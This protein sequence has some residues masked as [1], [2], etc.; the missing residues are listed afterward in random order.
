M[1]ILIFGMHDSI[2]IFTAKSIKN[3]HGDYGL[4]L[5]ILYTV[6]IIILFTVITRLGVIP[7]FDSSLFKSIFWYSLGI[8]THNHTF[9]LFRGRFKIVSGNIIQIL[10]AS[11]I[12][13][14][15]LVLEDRLQEIFLYTGISISMVSIISYLLINKGVSFR[16]IE[17]N[18]VKKI[19]NYGF[20][21]IPSFIFQAILLAGIPLLLAYELNFDDIAYFNTSLSLVRSFFLIIGPIGLVLLPLISKNI[22]DG[23]KEQISEKLY[24]LIRITIILSVYLSIIMFIYG[25]NIVFIWL[26]NISANGVIIVKGL[27]AII[28]FYAIVGIIRSP[29]DAADT[30]GYNSI[31]FSIAASVMICLYYILKLLGL[32]IIYVG[33]LSLLIGYFCASII[34]MYYIYKL[35]M[36]TPINLKIVFDLIG[37]T[38]VLVILKIGFD[39][40]LD[41]FLIKF[42]I[43]ILVSLTILTIFLYLHNYNVFRILKIYDSKKI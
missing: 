24:H 10:T 16:N 3:R 32:P 14:I 33:I 38:I 29:I 22:E 7:G 12:P 35:F 26:N 36:I 34:G 1:P 6:P 2:A 9:G 20:V 13:F 4:I 39:Y 37:L 31:I 40:Y 19:M 43:Y 8:S 5:L 42:I 41:V 23:N 30:K 15:V 18:E 27:V 11:I 25:P 28:P 17:W 21:R